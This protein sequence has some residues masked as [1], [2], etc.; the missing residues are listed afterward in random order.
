MVWFM[1]RGNDDA[2]ADLL[3]C[4]IRRAADALGYEFEMASSDGQPR[5]ERFDSPSALIDGYLSEQSRLIAAG[6]R[7]RRGDVT[8]LE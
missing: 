8:P 1:E 5:T 4:E 3:V 2:E 7:P 6:W